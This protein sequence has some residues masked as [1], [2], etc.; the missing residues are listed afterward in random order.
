MQLGWKF[1]Y[2]TTTK[3]KN[4]KKKNNAS[5][6]RRGE[7]E[8]LLI[9]LIRRNSI[10]ALVNSWSEEILIIIHFE[11]HENKSIVRLSSQLIFGWQSGSA[12]QRR[13]F[14]FSA[15]LARIWTRALAYCRDCSHFA[16]MNIVGDQRTDQANNKRTDVIA[17]WWINHVHP[18]MAF[19]NIC[20]PFFQTICRKQSIFPSRA[21]IFIRSTRRIRVINWKLW[22]L[23][24]SCAPNAISM[25]VHQ[26]RCAPE[27]QRIKC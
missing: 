15:S 14:P 26:C 13:Y 10:N 24:K 8:K 16:E 21:T 2:E 17:F 18:S 20:V 6:N 25:K 5:K 9:Y 4:R 7:G 23:V 12:S 19:R 3:R 11:P 27:W 1:Y 22:W